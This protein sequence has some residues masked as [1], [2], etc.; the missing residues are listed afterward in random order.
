MKQSI[1]L[2]MALFLT[3]GAMCQINLA[4]QV[5]ANMATAKLSYVDGNETIDQDNKSK[6]G[7]VGGLVAE[8]PITSSINFRPELN[9]SMKGY[10]WDES[11][12]FG[13]YKE[14][15]TM[16]YI[17]LPLNFTYNVPA[18]NHTVFF[19]LGPVIG[20]GLS[21]KVEA[22]YAGTEENADIK[23]DGEENPP[24]GDNDWHL[25]ALDFGAD[26]LAGFKLSNGAFI[27]AGYTLGFSNIHPEGNTEWKNRAFGIKI[28]YFFSGGKKK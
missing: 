3:V 27:S 25:N 26:I 8:I 18:G 5:G 22:N 23:F 13:E 1:I 10:K 17:E 14:D 2:I 15:V 9:Y 7:F 4:L 11:G 24:A 12:T 20:L 28:G 19:G 21:G 16:N 6:V